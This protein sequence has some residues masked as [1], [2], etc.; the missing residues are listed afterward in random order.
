MSDTPADNPEVETDN[1]ADVQ[2]HVASRREKM[3]KIEELGLDPWGGRF[4]DRQLVSEI[5]ARFDEIK[6]QKE[7][8]TLVDL[9]ELDVAPE[10]RVNMREWR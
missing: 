3:R 4:D 8:G 5:R 10:E 9:P 1:A 2:M 6:F 7:D